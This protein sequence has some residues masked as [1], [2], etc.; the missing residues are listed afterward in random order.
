MKAQRQA[1]IWAVLV[2]LLV[3]CTAVVLL[4]VKLTPVP[5]HIHAHLSISVDGVQQE[6]P[7]NIGIDAAT[8]VTQPLH[9]HDTTG[10]LHV[11]SPVQRTFTLGDFFVRSWHQQLDSTRVGDNVISPS[12]TLTV[13]VNQQPV[14]GDPADIVLTNKMDIDLVFTSAGTTA[15]PSAPFDWPPQY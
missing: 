7:A 15:S 13:F 2:G 6:V 10:I 5:E 3:V 14:Q 8:N 9:T 12:E 11:E 1:P 4:A